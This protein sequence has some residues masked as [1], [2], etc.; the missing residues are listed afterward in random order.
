MFVIELVMWMLIFGVPKNETF[1][2]L[3][4][5]PNCVGNWKCFNIWCINLMELEEKN[6]YIKLGYAPIWRIKHTQAVKK[7][8]KTKSEPL[9]IL[10]ALMKI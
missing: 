6:I 9:T 7:S 1:Q 2:R 3:E 8:L 10:E 5:I 4:I